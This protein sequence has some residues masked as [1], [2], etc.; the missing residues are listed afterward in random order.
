MTDKKRLDKMAFQCRGGNCGLY[1][2]R[3]CKPC[4]DIQW[5]KDKLRDAWKREEA[6]KIKLRVAEIALM[7]LDPTKYNKP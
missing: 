6:L 7:T 3:F 5:V 1:N 2:I 4:K